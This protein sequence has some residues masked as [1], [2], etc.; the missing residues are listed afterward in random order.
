MCRLPKYESVTRL[1]CR[2]SIAEKLGSVAVT[3]AAR[4]VEAKYE[5]LIFV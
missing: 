1:S 4:R 5:S 2:I 3:H